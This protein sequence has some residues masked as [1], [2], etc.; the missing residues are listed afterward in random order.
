MI[1]G[2]FEYTRKDHNTVDSSGNDLFTC[3]FL[4]ICKP[5]DLATGSGIT[6]EQQIRDPSLQLESVWVAISKLGGE[7]RKVDYEGSWCNSTFTLL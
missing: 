7:V 1:K 4:E 6:I 2:E 3:E 5:D